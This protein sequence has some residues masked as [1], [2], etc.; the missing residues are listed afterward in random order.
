MRSM[1]ATVLSVCGVGAALSILLQA[2]QMLARG[3]S[4][5]V[6]IIVVD[7]VGLACGAVTL[8]VALRLRGGLFS[9]ATWGRCGAESR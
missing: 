7:G 6:P 8:A 2:R 3:G 4:C 9:P 5:N 1:L